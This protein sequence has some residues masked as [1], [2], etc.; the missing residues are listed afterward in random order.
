MQ[1]NPRVL[2]LIFTLSLFPFRAFAGQSQALE[3]ININLFKAQL[4]GKRITEFSI[5]NITD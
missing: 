1:L 3:T 2:I 4:N 5:D